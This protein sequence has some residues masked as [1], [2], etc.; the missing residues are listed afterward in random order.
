MS[1]IISYCCNSVIWETRSEE[2]DQAVLMSVFLHG[3]ITLHTK[4]SFEASCFQHNF[5]TLVT[6]GSSSKHQDMTVA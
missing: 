1:L 3:A 5:K 4:G 2:D 6:R